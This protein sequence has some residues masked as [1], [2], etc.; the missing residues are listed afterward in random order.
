MNASQCDKL[1]NQRRTLTPTAALDVWEDARGAAVVG[2]VYACLEVHYCEDV[3]LFAGPM[4]EQRIGEELEQAKLGFYDFMEQGQPFKVLYLIA[5]E[6]IP[7]ATKIIESRL[8]A[9]RILDYCKLAIADLP[10]RS[11]NVIY[12]PE[13]KAN[14]TSSTGIH[15]LTS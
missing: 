3:L 14:E 6:K 4:F 9:L 2:L 11:W 1:L 8:N 12:P 10:S 13:L 15:E 7:E 5:E